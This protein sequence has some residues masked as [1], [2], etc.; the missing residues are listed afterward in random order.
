M[1]ER[2]EG[3]I[4]RHN[5]VN[6]RLNNIDERLNAQG[7]KLDQVEISAATFAIE[8]KALC[9]Q[10]QSL[11]TTLKWTVGAVLTATGIIVSLIK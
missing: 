10:I 7:N 2:N 6:E 8:I 1:V 11:V 9:S 5:H 3:C 4:E